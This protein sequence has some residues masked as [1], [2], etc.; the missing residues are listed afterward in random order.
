MSEEITDWLRGYACA[1]GARAGDRL[2]EA[3]DQI[4]RL[5]KI[6]RAALAWRSTYGIPNNEINEQL[7]EALDAVGREKDS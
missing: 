2:I 4:E 5:Q 3:A 6:E 1:S 7:L